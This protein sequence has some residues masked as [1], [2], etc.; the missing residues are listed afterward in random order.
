MNINEIYGSP[1]MVASDL[2]GKAFIAVIVAVDEVQ[3]KD[4]GVTKR[5][6]AVKLASRSGQLWRKPWLV[7]STNARTLTE[8]LGTETT[9]WLG[10]AIEIYSA[11]VTFGTKLVDGIRC[12]EALEGHTIP[13]QA[14]APVEAIAAP[15]EVPGPAVTAYTRAAQDELP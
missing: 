7:N 14:P 6:C 4:E 13:A 11:K 1:Y 10:R 5:R 12:R 9:A 3:L 2:R 15:A 8:L